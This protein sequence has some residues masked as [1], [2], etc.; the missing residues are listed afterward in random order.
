M[1]IKKAFFLM[2]M[3]N[4]RLAELKTRFDE[5]D[6]TLTIAKDGVTVAEGRLDTRRGPRRDR[7]VLQPRVRRGAPR[8]RP[9]P[10]RARALVLG[11]GRQGACR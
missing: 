7:G 5:R 1:T 6:H 3:K 8:S 2:L 4:E 10:V 9:H 11:H